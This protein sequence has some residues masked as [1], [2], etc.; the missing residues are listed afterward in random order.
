MSQLLSFN[1]TAH[2][3][4]IMVLFWR[5]WLAI[6]LVTGLGLAYGGLTAE[7][8]LAQQGAG[9]GDSDNRPI[10]KV[11]AVSG[12]VTSPSPC[13]PARRIDFLPFAAVNSGIWRAGGQ[14]RMARS[15]AGFV[16]R[17]VG[18]VD[19]RRAG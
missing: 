15:S 7:P 1:L 18:E 13:C 6:L 12:S 19:G 5:P 10:G 8:A 3:A 9:A 2:G 4:R 14:P 17:A 16:R 11:I